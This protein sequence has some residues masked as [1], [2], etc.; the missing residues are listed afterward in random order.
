M[1]C[2]VGKEKRAFDEN[3]LLCEKVAVLE[4]RRIGDMPLVPATITRRH[5]Y[6]LKSTTNDHVEHAF[7][8]INPSF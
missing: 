2:D 4:W 7:V 5:E 3:L 1:D 8:G 6:H